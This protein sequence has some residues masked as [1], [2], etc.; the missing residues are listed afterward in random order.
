MAKDTKKSNDNEQQTGS[1]TGFLADALRDMGVDEERFPTDPVLN[2][3]RQ[4]RNQPPDI[5]EN[6][7]FDQPTLV[8]NVET[9][10]WVPAILLGQPADWYKTEPLRFFS[11]S[12]GMS[13]A[14]SSFPWPSFS[15]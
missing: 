15:S 4:P 7:L 2:Q 9:Y 6:G 3:L 14:S 11:I 13:S 8:N 12:G 5:R 10:A 1:D